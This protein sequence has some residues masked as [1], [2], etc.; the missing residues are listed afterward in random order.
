MSTGLRHLA[1]RVNGDVSR[2]VI[3][4]AGGYRGLRQRALTVLA[5]RQH[6]PARR[7]DWEAYDVPSRAGPQLA[8]EHARR[9]SQYVNAG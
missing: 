8:W 4:D 2:P 7:K 1:G 9:W 6:P 3:Y 5:A